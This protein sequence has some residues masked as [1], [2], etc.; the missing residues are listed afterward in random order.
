MAFTGTVPSGE[1]Y[2]ISL[3]GNSQNVWPERQKVTRFTLTP[4]IF[5]DFFFHEVLYEV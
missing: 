1:G 3:H 2:V 4:S 5:V